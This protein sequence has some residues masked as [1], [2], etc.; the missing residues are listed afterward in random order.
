MRNDSGLLYIR[1]ELLYEPMANIPG[2]LPEFD[3]IGAVAELLA[4]FVFESTVRHNALRQS[5]L[6]WYS[7]APLRPLL[8]KK[9]MISKSGESRLQLHPTLTCAFMASLRVLTLM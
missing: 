6:K 7:F 1:D 8:L 2:D 3:D 4:S 5:L 9:P